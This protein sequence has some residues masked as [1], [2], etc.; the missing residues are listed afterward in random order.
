MKFFVIHGIQGSSFHGILNTFSKEFHGKWI[1]MEIDGHISMEITKDISMEFHG[2]AWRDFR[3]ISW[4]V[5]MEFHGNC[6]LIL[7]GIPWNFF[8]W[9]CM[10]KFP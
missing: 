1:F 5:S 10:D 3:G 6:V 7:Q 2:S 9:K 4:N 8:P